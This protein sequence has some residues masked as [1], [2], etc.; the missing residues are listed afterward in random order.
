MQTSQCVILPTASCGAA[1]PA[2]HS[3]DIE[4]LPVVRSVVP[5][6]VVHVLLSLDVG[7]LERNVVNQVREAGR[8][9]QRV[10]IICLERRGSLAPQAEE[11]GATVVSMGKL[12]GL[13]WKLFGNLT[14]LF[15]QIQPDVVHTHQLGTLL[16]GGRA[17]RSA[18]VSLVVHTEHGKENYS[19]LA[20]AVAGA[21]GRVLYIA[22]TIA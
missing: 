1:P 7:G 5:L 12:P 9:N 15:H 18:G 20:H 11:H 8:L 6:H 19:G 4:K 21:G 17:A 14:T 2:R 3:G 16:Y 22:L 10:T 13:S